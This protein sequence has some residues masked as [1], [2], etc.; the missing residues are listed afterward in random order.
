[1]NE[2]FNVIW[3]LDDFNCWNYHTTF[4]GR[5]VHAFIQKRPVYC[6]RGHYSFN[7][8]GIP[9]IDGADCFPRYFMS[10]DRAMIE[11]TLWVNWRLWRLRENEYPLTIARGDTNIFRVD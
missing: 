3:T 1:M 6:D 9:Y 2:T 11:A 8:D 5:D 4:E 10:L 7:I